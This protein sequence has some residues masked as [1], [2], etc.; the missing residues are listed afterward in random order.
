[1]QQLQISPLRHQVVHY[2]RDLVLGPYYSSS[3]G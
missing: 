3:L 2:S 1:L